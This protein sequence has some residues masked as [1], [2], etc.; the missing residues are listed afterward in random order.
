MNGRLHGGIIH[1]DQLVF[2]CLWQRWI[3]Q[4]QHSHKGR[5]YSGEAP[6]SPVTTQTVSQQNPMVSEKDWSCNS[7]DSPEPVYGYPSPC[8]LHTNT[9][10]HRL[11]VSQKPRPAGDVWT[12][13][14]ADLLLMVK[15]MVLVEMRQCCL[16]TRN[17]DVHCSTTGRGMY[18]DCCLHN[19][20]PSP[21]TP[22]ALSMCLP[23]IRFYK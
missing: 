17:H 7:E 2:W 19:H 16:E 21:Y 14:R 20:C 6:V 15:R 8:R 5:I 23:L 18:P 12:A 11:R 3:S 4:G 22:T 9:H 10:P 13:E 1:A